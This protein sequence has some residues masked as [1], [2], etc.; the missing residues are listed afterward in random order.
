MNKPLK[1]SI[2]RAGENEYIILRPKSGN[3][4]DKKTETEGNLKNYFR[5]LNKNL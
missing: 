2:K 1:K 5:N 3:R 4:I